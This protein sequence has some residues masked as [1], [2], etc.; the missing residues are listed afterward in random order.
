[1]T[2]FTVGIFEPLLN[3]LLYIQKILPGHDLGLAII[4]LTILIKVALYIPSLS[5]IRASRQLQTLQPRLK[6]IQEKYKNDR[7]TLAKEQMALY[8][9]SK[10]NPFASCL[11]LLIQIPFFIG[12]YQVFINGLKIDQ[13]GILQASVLKHVYPFLRSYYETTSIN[14]NFLGFLDLAKSHGLAN[15]VLAV[16]AGFAQ[17]WQTKML[18]AP[19]EPH[20]K[21]ARDESMA[22]ATTKQMTYIL[23]A[24]TAYLTYTF[25]AG[26]GL[27]WV[28]QSLL[29]IAQQYIFLR[30][31]P[32]QAAPSS[33]TPTIDGPTNAT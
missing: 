7:E 23:P 17:F 13:E 5:S 14:T 12:L 3:G 29:T 25:P 26:L 18:A 30:R 22:S 16:V 19:K 6:A 21:E 4:L 20:I 8:K 9:E 2:W 10:V 11:P 28:V 27:Y 15:I 31:H 1:M 33:P 32:L 24:F